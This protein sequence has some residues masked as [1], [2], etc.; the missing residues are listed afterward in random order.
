[1]RQRWLPMRLLISRHTSLTLWNGGTAFG[2]PIAFTLNPNLAQ[3]ATPNGST[4]TL[5]WLQLLNESQAYNTGT[6]SYGFQIPNQPGF[7]QLDNGDL[8]GAAAGGAGIGQANGPYYDSNAGSIVPPTFSDNPHAYAGPGNYLHFD[9][10][11]TWDIYTPA[12]PNVSPARD[13]IDIADYGVAWG[14]AIIPEPS[15]IGL[16]V[17]AGSALSLRRRR[18]VG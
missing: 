15:S 6:G 9:A 2:E 18:S 8:N 7:W 3:P 10:I 17:L 13:T 4:A 14:F 1:M 12:V 16:L 11:P 5:H